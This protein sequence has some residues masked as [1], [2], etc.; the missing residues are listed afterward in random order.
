MQWTIKY[1]DQAIKETKRLDAALKA[2]IKKF[3]VERL[4]NHE[5]PR[6]LGTQLVGKSEIWRYRIG[7]YQV[8]CKI[9]DQEITILVIEIGHRSKIYKRK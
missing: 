9:Q 6:A 4:A 3:L 8:L 7:D 2:R 5:N 1:N